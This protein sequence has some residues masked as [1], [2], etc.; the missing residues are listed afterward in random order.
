MRRIGIY[1]FNEVE[2]LDFAG[3]FETFSV[4]GRLA[5]RRGQE[6][7]F[8]VLT[9]AATPDPITTRGGLVV[10][11]SCSIA[12]H[13]P[14]DVVIV[15]GGV[16]DRELA[17]DD[18]IGWIARCADSCEV[19]A[20]VC[21]G[22]FV[23]GRAG[24]LDGRTVTTHWEDIADLRAAVPLANVV[25]NVK[26]VDEG[27]VVTAAGISAGIDMCLHLVERFE[28]LEFAQATARQMDYRWVTNA[29]S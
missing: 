17:S 18:V 27:D 19:V 16:M 2:V 21:T 24:L 12:N 15:P 22:A 29:A 11:P 8:E 25:E 3:P 9:V 5:A 20:S 23:L 7:P 26:W 10:R 14:L 6:P 4:A 1:V 13:P 28:G